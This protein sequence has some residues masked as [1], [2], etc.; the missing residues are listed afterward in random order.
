MSFADIWTSD[1][2]PSED[3]PK[4]SGSRE[5]F[6]SKET[7]KKKYS[8]QDLRKLIQGKMASKKSVKG[9]SNLKEKISLMKSDCK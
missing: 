5:K 6:V 4:R 3:S 1:S 9:K 8:G 7:P 2:E